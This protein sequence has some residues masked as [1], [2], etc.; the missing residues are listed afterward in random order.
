MGVCSLC[1]FGRMAEWSK[2]LAWSASVL[3]TVP[4]VRIPL[5]PQIETSSNDLTRLGAPSAC[6]GALARRLRS[7]RSPQPCAVSFAFL[8]GS[9][10]YL[11]AERQ[12]DGK[13]NGADAK[14]KEQCK[15]AFLPLSYNSSLC[16]NTR[17]MLYCQC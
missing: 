7:P 17:D 11:S 16:Y 15:D 6:S 4:W 14:L 9:S 1:F 10:P 12:N 2:A 5:L 3:E 8:C 13:G